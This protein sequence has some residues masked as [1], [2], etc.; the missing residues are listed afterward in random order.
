M[1]D[2]TDSAVARRA[3]GRDMRSSEMGRAHRQDPTRW[4][5]AS[6]A[7]ANETDHDPV[8]DAIANRIATR[9]MRHYGFREYRVPTGEMASGV[10][11]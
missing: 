8:I 1:S 5:R 11:A 9:H 6:A 2:G 3:S 7:D 4:R 10:R